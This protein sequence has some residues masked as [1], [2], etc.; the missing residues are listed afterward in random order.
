MSCGTS[1]KPVVVLKKAGGRASS[2]KAE[3]EGADG[4]LGRV[5]PIM[6]KHYAHS[7]RLHS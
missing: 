1:T 2:S 3:E 7:H 4:R 5:K 6:V